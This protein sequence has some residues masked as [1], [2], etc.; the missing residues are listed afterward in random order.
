MVIHSPPISEVCDS[1]PRPNVG[2]VLVA[3]RWL[4][5]IPVLLQYNLTKVLCETI[6]QIN[7]ER[8]CSILCIHSLYLMFISADTE[9]GYTTGGGTSRNPSY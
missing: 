2:K 1:N 3:Y 4:A 7:R 8:L 5:L 9:R 6:K